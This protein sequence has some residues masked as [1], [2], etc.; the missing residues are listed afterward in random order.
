M[1][2]QQI[3][4]CA[5]L[6]QV[7]GTPGS[8]VSTLAAEIRAW[9]PGE[10][11][12]GGRWLEVR[13]GQITIAGTI[14]WEGTPPASRGVVVHVL[15]QRSR[16]E[17][18]AALAALTTDDHSGSLGGRSEQPRS[19]Q[20]RSEEPRSRVIAVRARADL[21]WPPRRPSHGD[22]RVSARHHAS[23]ADGDPTMDVV[24]LSALHAR[25][26]R[27]LTLADL[28]SLRA[29]AS[30]SAHGTEAYWLAGDLFARGATA[31]EPEQRQRLLQVLD[32][33]GIRIAVDALRANQSLALDDI[34]GLMQQHSGIGALRERL[35]HALWTQS[36]ERAGNA[37]LG[38][39]EAAAPLRGLPWEPLAGDEDQA[40]LIERAARSRARSRAATSPRAARAALAEYQHMVRIAQGC[41]Q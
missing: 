16:R 39:T 11:P 14:E 24:A 37:R 32:L 30:A 26:P 33:T 17:D 5:G 8:G 1:G 40:T 4:P 9:W 35:A 7:I 28:G 34:G 31:I 41:A 27:V 15:G 18:R 19:E 22:S 12:A 6:V 21:W 3:A 23:S 13:E 29:L 2:E 36:A 10:S 20:P 38:G 25:A